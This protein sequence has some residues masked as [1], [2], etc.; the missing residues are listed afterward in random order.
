MAKP[1]LS[2]KNLSLNYGSKQVLKNINADFHKNR[3]TALI[4]ASG[5]GKSTLLWT[6]NRMHDL[7]DSVSITGLV[8]YE[9]ENI[10]DLNRDVTEIRSKIGMLFQNPTPFH[11]TI[12]DN[13]AYGLEIKGHKNR[14]KNWKNFFNPKGR[15]I[16]IEDLEKSDDYID[17]KVIQTLK[18]VYLWEEVKNRLF[19]S[20]T[21]FSGG[22]Q[23][24]LCI[25]R[26]LA[27]EP[28]IIL[29]DEPC[30]SLDPLSTG[31]IEKL[32]LEL[33][34]KVTIVIVTHNLPQAKR[35]ADYVIHMH[36]GEI[37]SHGEK[38]SLFTKAENP[39]TREYINGDFG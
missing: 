31:K 8:N 35:I 25:A 30:S 36:E 11:K 18:N 39:L 6:L 16:N 28:S 1:I 20:A 38:N 3:I 37:V 4:G 22:Q 24:R 23:Q 12:Y 5:S 15:R 27:I 34:T 14:H 29:L 26:A 7:N 2:I 17:K 10:L 13:I 19:E 21:Q 9:K 32:L 33:K